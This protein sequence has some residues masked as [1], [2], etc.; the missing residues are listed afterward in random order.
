MT[1]QDNTKFSSLQRTAR[2]GDLKVS[3]TSKG[4]KNEIDSQGQI[5]FETK[6]RQKNKQKKL[7]PQQTLPLLALLKHNFEVC[8]FYNTSHTIHNFFFLSLMK[9]YYTAA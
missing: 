8:K 9:H 4:V 1:V 2:Q 5:K 6:R 7:S 3:V